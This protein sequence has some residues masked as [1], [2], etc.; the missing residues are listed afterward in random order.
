MAVWAARNGLQ[1]VLEGECGFGRECVGVLADGKYPDYE[2][3]DAEYTE[4]VDQNGEVWAPKDAYHKHP[5]VAVLGRGEPA[6]VQLYEW[7]LW[8]DANGFVL[9][10]GDVELPKPMGITA[11]ILRD[12]W[13]HVSPPSVEFSRDIDLEPPHARGPLRISGEATFYREHGAASPWEILLRD[14]RG[15]AWRVSL[16]YCGEMPETALPDDLFAGWL[17]RVLGGT[18]LTGQQVD[19]LVT[20]IVAEV[21]AEHADLN[22]LA[23]VFRD[24][25]AARQRA[26]R[27]VAGK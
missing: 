21:A 18:C 16:E 24:M 27:E 1:L 20:A 22:Q 2:W 5:C 12:D 14:S 8:F 23:T 6:E 15:D 10:R 9:E 26:G 7:L 3:Y 11:I 17:R 4:R 13:I 25:K 19:R